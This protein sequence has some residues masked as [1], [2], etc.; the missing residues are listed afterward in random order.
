MARAHR[1]QALFVCCLVLAGLVLVAPASAAGGGTGLAVDNTATGET[2]THTWNTTVSSGGDSVEYLIVNYTGTGANLS[3]PGASIEGP[4]VTVNGTPVGVSTSVD[5]D[6][7]LNLTLSSPVQVSAN[8]PVEVTVNTVQ[9]PTVSGT[10]TAS[11]EL[12]NS[13]STFASTVE[14]FEIV[15][16]GH[17]NGTVTNGTGSGVTSAAVSVRNNTTNDRVTNVSS[18]GSGSYSAHVPAGDYFVSVSK[19]GYT[20]NSTTT[21]VQTNAETTFDPT[22]VRV[23]YINGTVLNDSDVSI[24]SA[25]VSLSDSSTGAFV[26]SNVSAADGSFS[27]AGGPGTYTLSVTADGYATNKTTAS[28]TGSGVTTT[29]NVTLAAL[30]YINGTVRNQSGTPLG[31]IN[32]VADSLT[33]TSAVTNTTAPDGSFSLA[34]GPGRYDLVAFNNPNYEFNITS[35]VSASSGLTTT[36]SVTLTAVPDSG[37]ISG[38]IVASDGTPVSGVTVSAGSSDYEHYNSTTTNATGYFS[39]EV[40]EDTYR[41]WSDAGSYAPVRKNGVE[42]TAT[43]TTSVSLTPEATAYLTGRVTNASGGVSG[44][45]VLATTGEEFHADPQTNATGHYNI[46]VPANG[47]YSVTVLATGQ[48]GSTKSVSAGA[49]GSVTTTDF[50]LVTTEIPVASVAI[51][52][53]PGDASNLGV[54][55][56]VS[57]GLLQ[58]QLVNESSTPAGSGVGKPQGLESLGLRSDTTVEINLTVTNFSADSLLWA[59][60]DA[61]FETSPN[62]TLQNGTDITIRGSPVDL[63]GT[64]N[65]QIGPLLFKDPDQVQWPTGRDS[66]ADMGFNQTVYAGVFDLDKAP[67]GVEETLKGMSVTTNAQSFSAPVVRN[68]SL[69]LWIAGPS[70]T[71]DG[72]EHTGFYQATIPDAQLNAWNVDDPESELSALFKGQSQDFTVTETQNGARIRLENITYSAGYVEVN[73]N[74]ESSSS[75]G[76][77]G[78]DD[79]DDVTATPTATPTLTATPTSV[80]TTTVSPTATEVDS[81]QTTD[82]PSTLAPTASDSSTATGTAA[83][84]ETGASTPGFGVVAA[85]L[86]LTA[87]VIGFRR[88]A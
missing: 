17:L 63:Q 18:G 66:R 52:D 29:Q 60:D 55:A 80:P 4:S 85:V 13:T 40:P 38:Q 53:G 34:V 51:T 5:S 62:E 10:Y 41:V 25:S 56:S 14:S 28:I 49:G 8:D 59:L 15:E 31:G 33:G 70:K 73:A 45:P 24:G 36:S 1:Q 76:S 23:G 47:S 58:M 77:S 61:R 16:G 72:D 21:T 43:G 71:V 11:L 9:N 19:S 27:V 44:I 48:S 83:G 84:T 7:R 35:N 3:S 22:I 37:N 30:G 6:T 12:N 81:V 87:A 68:D 42:V 82:T 65:G 2:T 32:L 57:G 75:G 78:S 54:R 67:G 39:M 88:R 64:S 50:D 46:S 20:S 74:P 86:A 79:S 26:D 69:R